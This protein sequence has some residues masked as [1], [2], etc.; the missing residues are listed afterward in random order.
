MGKCGL[1]GILPDLPSGQVVCV[2]EVGLT[3]EWAFRGLWDIVP[4]NGPSMGSGTSSVTFGQASSERDSPC[5][6]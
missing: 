2:R 6:F 5:V 1:S 3:W 4:G